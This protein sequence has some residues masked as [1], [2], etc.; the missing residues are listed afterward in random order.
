LRI[1][2]LT[3]HCP[4][5]TLYNTAMRAAFL[6]AP[7]AWSLAILALYA[8]LAFLEPVISPPPSTCDD[9]LWCDLRYVGIILDRTP[10]PAH[11]AALLI[12][13]SG[14]LAFLAAHVARADARAHWFMAGPLFAI[15]A[16]TALFAVFPIQHFAINAGA[17]YAPALVLVTLQVGAWTGIV[18]G[19]PLALL[20]LLG[21]WIRRLRLRARPAAV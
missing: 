1:R 3:L 16:A 18:A 13:P 11:L 10:S 5:R 21:A 4:K 7:L 2:P 14:L 17:S 9:W 20:T 12:I 8:P 6:R 15:V 19:L